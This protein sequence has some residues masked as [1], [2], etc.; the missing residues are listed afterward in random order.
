[1]DKISKEEV[2]AKIEEDTHSTQIMKII[3]QRQHHWIGH[4]LRHESLL[5]D[6]VE[7][8]MKGRPTRGRRRL[9][10]LHMLAKDGY[11]AMADLAILKGKFSVTFGTVS[12]PID[13]N[14]TV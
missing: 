5:M 12:F 1:M 11:V 2:L 6:T 7:L 8:R 4:I 3:Q 10:I 14:H 9:Q 13:D